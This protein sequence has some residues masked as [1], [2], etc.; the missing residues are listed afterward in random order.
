MR[1]VRPCHGQPPPPAR[2]PTHTATCATRSGDDRRAQEREMLSGRR[3]AHYGRR[4]G[5]RR[6]N[7][8]SGQDSTGRTLGATSELSGDSPLKLSNRSS[9]RSAS[10]GP[11]S[12]PRWMGSFGELDGA[13]AGPRRIG[14]PPE[15]P[16]DAVHRHPSSLPGRCRRTL[17]SPGR[18][19]LRK[20]SAS[21]CG[22][23]CNACVVIG[24]IAP[25]SGR[26]LGRSRHQRRWHVLRLHS[27]HDALAVR[28]HGGGCGKS[29]QP[30][31]SHGHRMAERESPI[32]NHRMSGCY[33]VAVLLTARA[34]RPDTVILR[35]GL[36]T[37]RQRSRGRAYGLRW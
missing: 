8:A 17:R 24:A 31:G 15:H 37:S 19:P 25:I 5:S 29:S 3:S 32:R 1:S 10:L 2:R 30:G 22:I 13:H 33:L 7:S 11:R 20:N 36:E 14:R 35:R 6:K 23:W 34:R 27:R 9:R 18:L 28:G 26:C 12:V 16:R 21:L 4:R